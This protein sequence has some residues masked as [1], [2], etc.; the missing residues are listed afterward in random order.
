[1]KLKIIVEYLKVNIFINRVLI[2]KMFSNNYIWFLVCIFKEDYFNLIIKRGCLMVLM[3]F[4]RNY[5]VLIY[6]VLISILI[7]NSF[8][9][10]ADAEP[11][12]ISHDNDKKSAIWEFNDE[13]FYEMNNTV[14]KDGAVLLDRF[15]NAWTLNETSDF[16]KGEIE[17]ITISDFDDLELLNGPEEIFIEIN[18][19]MGTTFEIY[20]GQYGYQT[21]MVSQSITISHIIIL[22]EIDDV[23]VSEDLIVS[24][25]TEDGTALKTISVPSSNFQIAMDEIIVDIPHRIQANKIYRIG[26][27]SNESN[28]RYMLYGGSNSVYPDGGFF[29]NQEINDSGDLE[30]EILTNQYALQGV[31]ESEIFSPQREVV[32]TKFIWDGEINKSTGNVMI[33]FRN[34]NSSDTEDG[35]WANWSE[36]K[37][38]TVIKELNLLLSQSSYIQYKIIL[39]TTSSY[40]SPLINSMDIIFERYFSMGTIETADFKTTKISRWYKFNAGIEL[41]SQE[42]ELLYSIDSGKTWSPTE[43][44]RD[45]TNSNVR[46]ERIRFRIKLYSNS[47][48]TTSTL[49]NLTI[50]F[51]DYPSDGVSIINDPFA[52]GIIGTSVGILGFGCFGYATETGKYSL[53]KRLLF[54]VIPLYHRIEKEKV[55]DHYLRRQIYLY[56]L[57][58]PGSNY[59]EIMKDINLKNGVLVYHLKTLEREELIKS[60]RDGMYRRFY[61]MEMKLKLKEFE[62]LSWFQIGIYNLIRK[63]PGITPNEITQELGKSKQVINYHLKIMKNSGLIRTENRGKYTTLF[64][65]NLESDFPDGRKIS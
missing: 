48:D 14:I 54:L 49:G 7:T 37:D 36:L 56:I 59:S 65:V 24:L 28:G 47:T 58:N 6:L 20:Q 3:R 38:I 21:F 26:F 19:D 31:F 61:P 17:N 25:E 57:S 42:A 34:G 53:L 18:T 55:L 46:S 35:T 64:M 41:N 23:S 44:I 10:Y 1:M 15:S 60:N 13:G 45:D 22:A 32:W 29:K 8:I 30:I 12:I 9:G 51:A 39:N 52:L 33:Q 27:R 5:S 50:Y 11:I 2:V 62:D 63:N 4:N 40:E 43:N 16:E